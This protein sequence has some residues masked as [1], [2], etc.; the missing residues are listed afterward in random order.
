MPDVTNTIGCAVARRKQARVSSP[1]RRVPELEL[2][3]AISSFGGALALFA[4]AWL[5]FQVSGSLLVSILVLSAG[6][7]PSL[8]LMKTSAKLPR[9][10]DVRTLC[11]CVSLVK[12]GV[13]ALLAL[14]L[15]LGYVSVW[16]LLVGALFVGVLMALYTPAYNLVLRSIAPVGHL[17]ALDAALAS[18][19]AVA[20]V[21][22]LL[23]GG[24]LMHRFGGPLVFLVNAAS[25]LP[26]A[27]F[28]L[29][30]PP[31]QT[32]RS[33]DSASQVAMRETISLIS[34]TPL[35]RRV[36]VLT[37]VFQ[38]LAWPLTRVLQ[39]VAKVVLDNPITFALLLMSF[40][41][42]A[43]LVAP[44]LKLSQKR[45]GYASIFARSALVLVVAL[46]L[47][48]VAGVLPSGVAHLVA[49]MVVLVPFGLAVN[50]S[51]ALLQAC[52]QVGAPDDGE[53]SILAIYSAVVAIIG[54]IGALLISELVAFVSIWIIVT[55]EGGILAVLMGV[56]FRR[57]WFADLDAASAGLEE[58]PRDRVLRHHWGRHRDAFGSFGTGVEPLSTGKHRI[59]ERSSSQP[60]PS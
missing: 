39:H 33:A 4:I 56:A 45:A 16:L 23:S 53:S 41:V 51:A 35:L 52:M 38:L 60:R 18:W 34:R 25:Y 3:V 21:A 47:V 59:R 8:L 5:S 22:G 12:G 19:T 11:A 58:H 7:V 20:T 13:F 17:D 49:I 1:S 15:Q 9:R 36:V 2:V 55:V 43:I 48:G 6:A 29:R 14:V 50:L 10:Y 31:V 40:Q 28:F 24:L 30:L 37:M 26:I 27:I 57:R 46:V 42:G 44:V 54:L 32:T